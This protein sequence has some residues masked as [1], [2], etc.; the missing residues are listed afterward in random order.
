MAF[1]CHNDIVLILYVK[2]VI[3]NSITKLVFEGF[4]PYTCDEIS[5]R[6]FHSAAFVK[7]RLTAIIHKQVYISSN[8]SNS[9][10]L[11]SSF[12]F[13]CCGF[14]HFVL[15]KSQKNQPTLSL[16]YL[17]HLFSASCFFSCFLLSPYR[18][19]IPET[20]K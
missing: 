20:G 18:K 16:F 7:V 15:V 3:G 6:F 14:P 12:Q 10:G 9:F 8:L 13:S 17:K 2:D 11:F 4:F 1:C 5:D 19:G